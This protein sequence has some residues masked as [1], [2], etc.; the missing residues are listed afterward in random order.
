MTDTPTRMF[1]LVCIL[2]AVWVLVYWLYQPRPPRVTAD[3]IDRP[4]PVQPRIAE[5][6]PAPPETALPTP[7][8]VVAEPTAPPPEPPPAIIEPKFREYVVQA[9]DVSWE[10]I[11][12]RVYGDRRMADVIARAN[13][14]NTSDR[15]KPGRTI[16]RIPL[17]PTNIQGKP[18]P[19]Y[20]PAA[21][22]PESP[23]AKPETTYVIQS[24]DTLWDIAKKVY[25]KGHMWKVIYEANRDVIKNPDRPVA[26]TVLRIPAQP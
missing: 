12:Q 4:V 2:I 22:S 8:P 15:L 14:M 24:D 26:G 9:G 25:G 19:E 20:K 10:R 3:V 18:N 16:L 11:A 17:D 21:P 23:K 6:E 5:P 1:G 13:P 7:A